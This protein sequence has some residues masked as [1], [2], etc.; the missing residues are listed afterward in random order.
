MLQT[1]KKALWGDKPTLSAAMCEAT[2]GHQG[3]MVTVP[4]LLLDTGAARASY[5]GK[6]ILD[7]VGAAYEE[8]NHRVKLGDGDTHVMLN[9]RAR[10]LVFI[11]G[12]DGKPRPPINTSFYVMP[13]LGEEIIIGLPDI[14]GPYFNFFMEMM[15][16]ARLAQADSIPLR[17]IAAE[18]NFT[19]H[20]K[21]S[22]LD[23]WTTMGELAPEEEESPDP[24]AF[25]EDILHF[26]EVSPEE[27]I[28]EYLAMLE[29]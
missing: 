12:R 11:R 14:L 7:K 17:V 15:Q 4:K 6:R 3:V 21:G 10:V 16:H 9:Q 13:K 28:V 25:G 26:M 23:P 27:A 19:Q 22:L 8:C 24:T 1:I 2:I 29:E 20:E 5:A 18:P